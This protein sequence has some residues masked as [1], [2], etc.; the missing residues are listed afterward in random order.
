M[1]FDEAFNPVQ[2]EDIDLSYRLRH[3]GHRII[4]VPEVE[5]YHFENV[6]T[7][8]STDVRGTYRIIKHGLLFKERWRFMFS[9]ENGPKDDEIRWANVEKRDI[10]EIKELEFT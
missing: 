10:S 2:Y 9:K 1:G 5:M 3:S 4:H 8:G 6:T 7:Q